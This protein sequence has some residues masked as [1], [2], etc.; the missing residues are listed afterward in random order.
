MNQAPEVPLPLAAGAAAAACPA[1]GRAPGRGSPSL[2]RWAPG[3]TG[4]G[5]LPLQ[6][7]ERGVPDVQPKW[8][9]AACWRSQRMIAMLGLREFYCERATRP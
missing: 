5:A 9:C 7:A 4:P 1:R 3:P 6:G 2:R 8:A